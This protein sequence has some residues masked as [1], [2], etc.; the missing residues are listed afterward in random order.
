MIIYLV[1]GLGVTHDIVPHGTSGAPRP[2]WTDRRGAG[3]STK[4]CVIS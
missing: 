2:A 4:A 3:R 1:A